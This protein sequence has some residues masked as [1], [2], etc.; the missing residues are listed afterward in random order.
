MRI[1]KILVFV[2]FFCV[3]LSPKNIY[4]QGHNHNG[5]HQKEISSPFEAKKQNVSLHCLLK[6]HIQH[7]YCP[8]SNSTTENKIPLSIASDCGGK[9]SGNLPNTALFNYDFTEVI[10]IRLVTD[11]LESAFTPNQLFSF[12]RFKDSLSHPP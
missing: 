7:G 12:H 5:H 10:Q 1:F 11:N 6:L 4:A 3:L 9:T 8:H 2:V